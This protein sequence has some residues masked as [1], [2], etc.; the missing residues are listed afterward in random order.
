MVRFEGS[1]LYGRGASHDGRYLMSGSLRDFAVIDTQPVDASG[2]GPDLI[3]GAK[4]ALD[5]LPGWPEYFSGF[6]ATADG[7]AFYGATSAY[8]VLKFGAD[9]KVLA[10]APAL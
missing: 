10:I 4:G 8:R 9:G 5:K 2:S 1:Y 3:A 7:K 6:D